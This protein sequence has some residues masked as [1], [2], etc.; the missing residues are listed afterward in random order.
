MNFRKEWL[1]YIENEFD[2]NKIYKLNNNYRGIAFF[3]EPIK[4]LEDNR[5]IPIIDEAKI[6]KILN[7]FNIERYVGD[8]TGTTVI[9]PYINQDNRYR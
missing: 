1:R 9:V 2:H 7:I 5:T 6:Q 3:G 4:L 8:Q